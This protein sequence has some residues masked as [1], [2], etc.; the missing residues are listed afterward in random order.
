MVEEAA[1]AEAARKAVAE[2]MKRVKAELRQL[3]HA[4]EARIDDE[5]LQKGG[6]TRMCAEVRQATELELGHD[7]M[8]CPA[9][10]LDPTPCK[11]TPV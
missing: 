10:P 9:T 7:S 6:L 3:R 5:E 11:A 2:E 8:L 1:E 4:A